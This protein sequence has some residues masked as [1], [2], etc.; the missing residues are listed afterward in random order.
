MAKKVRCTPLATRHDKHGQTFEWTTPNRGDLRPRSAVPCLSSQ[1][2]RCRKL[3]NGMDSAETASGR[4]RAGVGSGCLAT[5]FCTRARDGSPSES[6]PLS[7]RVGSS[8]LPR[9]SFIRFGPYY[10]PVST[11]DAHPLGPFAGRRPGRLSS[12]FLLSTCS[13][14]PPS[15]CKTS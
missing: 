12:I 11:Y 3:E 6:P 2:I 1:R 8:L 14:S 7:P 4:K 15:Y 9:H 5:Y 13:T 10:C